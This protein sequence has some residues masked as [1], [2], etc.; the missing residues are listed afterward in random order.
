M[1]I[2]LFVY[3]LHTYIKLYLSL[4]IYIYICNLPAPGTPIP[5]HPPGCACGRFPLT[6]GLTVR[7]PP[8]TP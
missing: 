4:Y 5:P 6:Q 2:T 7:A 3:I 1:Y 8:P